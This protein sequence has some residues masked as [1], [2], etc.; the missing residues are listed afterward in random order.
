MIFTLPVPGGPN[1][2]TPLQGYKMPVNKWGYF[3][4]KE[5]AYFR[6]LLASY[7]PTISLNRTV[8][9]SNL[10]KKKVKTTKLF[11]VEFDWWI[12]MNAETKIVIVHKPAARCQLSLSQKPV[13]CCVGFDK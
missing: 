1:K 7:R 6:S 10:L 5:T 11:D 4:G 9:K 3:K 8:A 2:R 12:S 13:L